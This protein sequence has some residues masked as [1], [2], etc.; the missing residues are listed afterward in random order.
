MN[1]HRF[2]RHFTKAKKYG[3]SENNTLKQWRTLRKS[4]RYVQSLIRIKPSYLDIISEGNYTNICRH[5][6]N[7]H[8]HY[9]K[10][11][12]HIS[13]VTNSPHSPYSMFLDK[14]SSLTYEFC[15]VLCSRSLSQ[16]LQQHW[17]GG[18]AVASC[19]RN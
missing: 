15:V 2:E 12:K 4:I 14:I 13:D 17:Y 3:G 8:R 5:Y 18:R 16:N 6:I 9:I 19:F 10:K 7:L 11:L 1:F